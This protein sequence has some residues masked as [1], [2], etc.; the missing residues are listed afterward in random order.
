MGCEP[1]EIL[2]ELSDLDPQTEEDW[3]L[4]MVL[5][6]IIERDPSAVRAVWTKARRD[7]TQWVSAPL[8]G[9][10]GTD[11]AHKTSWELKALDPLKVW[12][13]EAVVEEIAAFMHPPIIVPGLTAHSDLWANSAVWP[14][15]RA[16]KALRDR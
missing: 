14:L 6:W 7:A 9:S 2:L 13:V 4:L 16:R 5:V 1:L 3:T 11:A 8:A 10:D 12:D 15:A